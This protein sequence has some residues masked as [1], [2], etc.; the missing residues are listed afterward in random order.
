MLVADN[1]DPAAGN[2]EAEA[3][4]LAARVLSSN[5]PSKIYLSQLGTAATRS[6]IV[7]SFDEGA[8]LVSYI[9]HGGI[10]LW[11]D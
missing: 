8:S 6:A 7:D 10:R 5:H 9:G 1:P 2:F 4:T 3:D 11:A